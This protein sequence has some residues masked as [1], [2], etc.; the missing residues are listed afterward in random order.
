MYV[1]RL[2]PSVAVQLCLVA[3]SIA[4]QPA[5]GAQFHDGSVD[6]HHGKK[7]KNMSNTESFINHVK[8]VSDSLKSSIDRFDRN[9]DG[10]ASVD[11]SYVDPYGQYSTPRDR[12]LSSSSRFA[13]LLLAFLL[14]LVIYLSTS[15]CVSSWCA[16]CPFN[17]FH[18]LRCRGHASWIYRVFR[19]IQNGLFIA[20]VVALF[21]MIA[22]DD[23]NRRIYQPAC[24]FAAD[25]TVLAYVGA[26][27]AIGVALALVKM[28]ISGDVA[29]SEAKLS[30]DMDERLY[31][32]RKPTMLSGAIARMSHTNGI[33]MATSDPSA[34][35]TE[36]PYESEDDTAE[37]ETGGSSHLEGVCDR[38][39]SDLVAKS[40]SAHHDSV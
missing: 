38:K 39:D 10:T 15:V 21:F 1:H 25:A 26:W 18:P 6:R 32:S 14:V 28:L 24:D 33:D 12:P 31:Q 37:R 29:C 20:M 23:C 34:V 27:S 5:D 2:V 8:S 30:K 40:S 36:D 22:I 9:H 4:A 3:S 13:Q 35:R 7:N 17:C 11:Q 16:C 19:C